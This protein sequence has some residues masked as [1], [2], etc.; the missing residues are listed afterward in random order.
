MQGDHEKPSKQLEAAQVQAQQPK[1]LEDAA[2]QPEKQRQ[3]EMK[4][5]SSCEACHSA[6]PISAHCICLSGSHKCTPFEPIFLK[7]FHCVN[8]AFAVLLI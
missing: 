5:K 4:L 2:H 7:D 8:T 6:A 3:V 1:G